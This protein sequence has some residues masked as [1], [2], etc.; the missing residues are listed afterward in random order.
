LK[1]GSRPVCLPP[2]Y[3]LVLAEIFFAPEDGGDMFFEA[4]VASQQ[5]TLRHIPEDD[6]L[7]NHRCKNLKSYKGTDDCLICGAL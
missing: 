3:L 4:S 7:H 6:T 1:A 2:A 5:T